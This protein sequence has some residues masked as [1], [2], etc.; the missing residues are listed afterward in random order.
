M[1][2]LEFR[3]GECLV[4][5]MAMPPASRVGTGFAMARETSLPVTAN[6]VTV[7]N[8]IV[9]KWKEMAEKHPPTDLYNS[10]KPTVKIST[11]TRDRNKT[12]D[13]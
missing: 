12:N 1:L 7:S 5:G 13:T 11:T 8:C 3:R 4:S 9:E 6:M 2:S 10:E